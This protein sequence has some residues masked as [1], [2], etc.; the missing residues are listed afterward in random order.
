M[1]ERLSLSLFTVNT[2]ALITHKLGFYIHHDPWSFRLNTIQFIFCFFFS[3]GCAVQLCGLSS[4]RRDWT[5]AQAMAVKS[6]NP[7][8]PA[9]RELPTFSFSLPRNSRPNSRVRASS[10]I[11]PS[12]VEAGNQRDA[13][14]WRMRILVV[15]LSVT[16]TASPTSRTVPVALWPTPTFYRKPW[17]TAW[18]FLNHNTLGSK[19]D[20][21]CKYLKMSF[22]FILKKSLLRDVEK[23]TVA[24]LGFKSTT[25]LSRV[26]FLPNRWVSTL[27]VFPPALSWLWMW[28][29]VMA[30]QAY[31]E[32][33]G[34]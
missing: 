34:F 16:H 23:Y 8:H 33:M 3:F 21:F 26:L 5:S 11:R 6:W 4:L 1:T 19:P 9:S 17:I 15:T 20:K 25:L 28:L 30:S 18:L 10:F 29:S 14:V 22:N 7:N 32:F 24:R 31:L 2:V 12:T 27:S 13:F